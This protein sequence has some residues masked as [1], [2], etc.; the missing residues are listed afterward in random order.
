MHC[1]GG[2]LSRGC[3]PRGCLLWGCL[4]GGG[5]VPGGVSAQGCLPS[6]PSRPWGCLPKGVSAQGVWQ[7][8]HDKRQTPL[9]WTEWETCVKTLPCPN[10]IAGGN[11]IPV[12]VRAKITTKKLSVGGANLRGGVLVYYLAIFSSKLHEHEWNWIERGVQ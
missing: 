6:L 1:T 2:C 10:F 3:L 9:L 4:P 8:P 5:Y 11:Y 7:T 12:A